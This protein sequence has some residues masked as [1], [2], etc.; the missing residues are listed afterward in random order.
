MFL[1]DYINKNAKGTLWEVTEFRII[2][3]SVDYPNV[4]HPNRQLSEPP[5][6]KKKKLPC[7]FQL[8]VTTLKYH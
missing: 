2:Q 5:A 4:N 1:D 8:L 7:T 3:Y 6:V